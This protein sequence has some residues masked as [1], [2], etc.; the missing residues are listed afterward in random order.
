MLDDKITLLLSEGIV[1]EIQRVLTYLKIRKH[2]T[3]TDHQINFWVTSLEMISH[4]VEPR[5]KYNP[6][7]IE[8]PKD[9]NLPYYRNGRKG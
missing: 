6:I 9:D 4:C 5:F 8:D 3:M 7:V 1:C 2:I